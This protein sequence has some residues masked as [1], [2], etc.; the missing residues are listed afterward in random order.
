MFGWLQNDHENSKYSV[1]VQFLISEIVVLTPA[2]KHGHLN[3]QCYVKELFLMFGS[4]KKM[5]NKLQIFSTQINLLYIFFFT[6]FSVLYT[7]ISK[8]N[9]KY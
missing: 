7:L 3:L 8:L 4:T 9:T 1:S 2:N 6:F 5:K